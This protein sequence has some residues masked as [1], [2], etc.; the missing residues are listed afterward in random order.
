[1][2]IV[3]TNAQP[4]PLRHPDPEAH[5]PGCLEIPVDAACAD[6]GGSYLDVFCNCHRFTEPKILLNGT[7][8]AW[9]AG[10]DERQAGRWRL[11]NHLVRPPKLR[12]WQ[13]TFRK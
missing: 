3:S 2:K 10:W 5:E 11:L 1:M 4:G 8:I 7:D 12:S 13:H 9:P 6:P